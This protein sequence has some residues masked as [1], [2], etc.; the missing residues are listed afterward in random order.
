VSRCRE[1]GSATVMAD[2]MQTMLCTYLSGVLLVGL[3]FN[4]AFGWSWADP[5]AALV[6][7]GVAGKEGVE[8]WRGEHCD[9]CAP[10][11]V[12]QPDRQGC[13]CGTDCE[14]GC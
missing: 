7:A 9:D 3:V 14:D 1:L 4:A 12:E 8:A 10:I 6:I 2:S 5:I 13:A 11:V